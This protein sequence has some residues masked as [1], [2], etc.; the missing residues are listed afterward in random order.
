[1]EQEVSCRMCRWI[2]EEQEYDKYGPDPEAEGTV[3]SVRD[4]V[5]T[6]GYCEFHLAQAKREQAQWR[7]P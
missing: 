3:Y 4:I 1:M 7:M 2:I 5:S 6:D